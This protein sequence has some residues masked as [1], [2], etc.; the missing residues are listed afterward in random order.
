MPQGRSRRINV[1]AQQARQPD[2]KLQPALRAWPQ[3][4]AGCG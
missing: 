4:G 3:F 2:A 1:G